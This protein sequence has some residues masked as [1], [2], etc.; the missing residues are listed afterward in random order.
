[1]PRYMSRPGSGPEAAVGMAPELA[2]RHTFDFQE[3][4][5]EIGDIVEAN[6]VADMRDVSVR[7]HQQQTG[8][9]DPH[10]IDEVDE[11]VSRGSPEETREPAL[12]HAELHCN[13]AHP[14]RLRSILRTHV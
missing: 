10:A 12:G 9:A 7:L 4:P 1:M 13:L 5:V 2:W 3:A 8:P 11:I 14:R 6:V